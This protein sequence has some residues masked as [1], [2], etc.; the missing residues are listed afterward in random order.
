MVGYLEGKGHDH[1]SVVLG[2]LIDAEA[3]LGT[4]PGVGEHGHGDAAPS[5]ARLARRQRRG[6]GRRALAALLLSSARRPGTQGAGGARGLVSESP[7]LVALTY[8]R[9]LKGLIDLTHDADMPR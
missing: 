7:P 3:V 5:A 9:M 1:G 8:H 4:V 2:W 6:R